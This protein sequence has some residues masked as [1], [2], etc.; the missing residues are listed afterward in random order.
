MSLRNNLENNNPEKVRYNTTVI[1][2]MRNGSKGIKNKNIKNFLDLPLFYWT[3]KK[4]YHLQKQGKI[5]KI[6]VSSDSDWYLEL[7]KLRFSFMSEGGLILSKRTDDLATDFTTTEETCINELYKYGIYDGV[8]GIVEV[9][10][11]L[12]PIDDLDLMFDSID[13]YVD[14]SFI[15]Y[16]DPFH[17]WKCT[18][19]SNYK[20]EKLYHDR[21]MRQAQSEGLYKEAGA[22]CVKI[23]NFM[24]I[25]N[26]IIDPVSPII[27]DKK[28]GL[29]IDDEDDFFYAEEL[30]KKYA[31]QIFK[32]TGLYK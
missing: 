12:I 5:N 9:T 29:S 27:I 17:F 10:S 4:L 7:V 3:I 22:W 2:P 8:L 32:D 19:K 26:R 24:E 28:F 31:S 21:K 16:R 23:P 15:V 1:V 14:S 20:W 25:K 18:E 6:I 13:D 11:P 30:M